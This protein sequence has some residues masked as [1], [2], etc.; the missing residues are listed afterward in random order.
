MTGFFLTY[1]RREL[2]RRARDVLLVAAALGGSVGL[3]MTVSA[4]SSA[5]EGAQD[6]MFRSLYGIG[7]VLAVTEPVRHPGA[8]G[9]PGGLFPGDLGMLS[10]AVAGRIARLP[11]VT[12]VAGD[13]RLNEIKPSPTGIPQTITVTG[14]DPGATAGPLA[15]ARIA[16][17]RGFDRDNRGEAVLAAGYAASARLKAGSAITVARHIFRVVGLVRAG[18]DSAD[19]YIPLRTAQLLARTSA[20]NTIYAVARN[21]ADVG[22]VS[23]EIARLLPDAT[24]TSQGALAAQVT[25]SLGG[26]ARLASSL[27]RWVSIAAMAA[28]LAVAAVF[29]GAAVTRRAREFGTLKALGWTGGRVIAQVMGE[30]AATGLAAVVTG[31]CLGLAG[32]ALVNHLAPSLSGSLPEG[33]G[34]VTVHLVAHAT[35]PIAVTAAGVAVAGTLGAGCL[36]AWRAARLSP[37]AAFTRPV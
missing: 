33:G 21:A 7:T 9:D 34:R 23:R 17:G 6:A 32:I 4:A 3:V 31:T 28:A 14:V 1:L 22:D 18:N 19:I 37:A 5:A 8:L 27:G 15:G 26:A 10:P 30:S 35:V 12:A 25:S 13:L 2:R 36:G 24:V 11:Q 20:V 29:S 16:S